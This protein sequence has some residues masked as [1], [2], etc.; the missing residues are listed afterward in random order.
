MDE[1]LAKGA[2]EPPTGG[3]GF[4]SNIFVVPKHTGG[5]HPIHNLKQFNWYV[6]VPTF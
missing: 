1:L 6:H 3:V 4:Y 5:L 2:I